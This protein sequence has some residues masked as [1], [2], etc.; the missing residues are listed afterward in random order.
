MK[1]AWDQLAS[2]FESSSVLVGDVD[3]TEEKELCSTFDVKGYPTIKYFKDGDRTGEAYNGG[4]DFD[5]LKKFTQDDLEVQ[6]DV[7]DPSQCDEKEMKFITSMKA[8]G[9]DDITKQLTRLTGMLS[10][11][12]K[13]ELKG[14]V[15][16]R[17]NILKQLSVKEEL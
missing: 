6:C 1:P 8:K 7:K 11:P 4:R 5:A 16:K 12:M 13:A 15:A 17:V 9:A 14:W 2:E 3:C 10:K